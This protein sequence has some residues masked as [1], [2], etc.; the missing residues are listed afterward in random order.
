MIHLLVASCQKYLI[1]YFELGAG[2]SSGLLPLCSNTLFK[3]CV[4]T[5][6]QTRC[7]FKHI[8]SN[9]VFKQ[10]C[11]CSNTCSNNIVFVQTPCSNRCVL[12]QTPCSNNPC[13]FKHIVQ[14]IMGMFKQRVQTITCLFKQRVHRIMRLFIRVF[15]HSV[16][17]FCASIF[18]QPFKHVYGCFKDVFGWLVASGCF[19]DFIRLSKGMGFSFS[20]DLQ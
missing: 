15:K 3:H 10:S 13:L 8:C 14:T 9:S 6:I 17:T 7:G 11:V 4:Q 5:H 2:A 19:T 1:C 20:R 16:Q 12:V 18:V